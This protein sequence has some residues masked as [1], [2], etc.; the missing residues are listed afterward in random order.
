MRSRIAAMMAAMRAG[1]QGGVGDVPS[2]AKAAFLSLLTAGLKAPFM[3][4][5][6][7]V[8]LVVAGHLARF[9]RDLGRPQHLTRSS[10]VDPHLANHERDVGHPNFAAAEIVMRGAVVG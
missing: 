1:A 2:A 8:G 6:G 3:S 5:S 10:A 9:P 4:G 7:N